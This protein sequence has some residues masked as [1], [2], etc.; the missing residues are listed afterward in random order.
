MRPSALCNTVV[1]HAIM[2]ANVAAPENWRIRWIPNLIDS[3][4]VLLICNPINTLVSI[5]TNGHFWPTPFP[6]LSN[7]PSL[8]PLTR[9][10]LSPSLSPSPCT[11]HSVSPVVIWHKY[12]DDFMRWYH[13]INLIERTWVFHLG[14][15]HNNTMCNLT[16]EQ[17]INYDCKRFSSKGK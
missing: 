5:F 1:N 15:A 10:S 13:W 17:L 2:R 6:F 3:F 4:F 12:S 11:P 8:T 14:I 9:C 7:A 16:S